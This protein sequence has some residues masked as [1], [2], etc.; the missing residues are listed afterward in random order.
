ALCFGWIDSLSVRREEG[1]R[2]Q[3]FT[4]RRPRSGWSKVNRERVARLVADGLM[5]PAG[6]AVVEH[7]KRTGTWSALADP[8]DLVVPDDLRRR[9]AADRAA[10]DNFA[11]FPPSA[12]RQ[13]LVWIAQ[14]KRPRTREK[15]IATTVE[16][17]ARDVRANDPRP[18]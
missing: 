10:R 18:R 9:L 3:R 13:V 2:Y 15:R 5:A 16:L 8:Q 12:R 1:G 6:L 7:A 14:A 4:P 17:A 11:A